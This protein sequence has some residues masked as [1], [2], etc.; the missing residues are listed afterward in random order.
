[1]KDIIVAITDDLPKGLFDYG[2][3]KNKVVEWKIPDE[4]KGNKNN[5]KRI[6]KEI[7]KRVN[8]LVKEYGVEN[9]N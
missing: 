8:T 4:L 9:Q 2:P 1:M 6:I 5:T 7:I 3:Y